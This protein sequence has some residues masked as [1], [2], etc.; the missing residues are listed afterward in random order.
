MSL[1]TV[2]IGLDAF[3]C[4]GR[5]ATFALIGNWGTGKTYF[6][7]EFIHDWAQRSRSSSKLRWFSRLGKRYSARKLQGYAY[8]SLFGVN[9]LADFRRKVALDARLLA[10]V[11]DR[12]TKR[13][14]SIVQRA[15]TP[16]FWKRSLQFVKLWSAPF[17]ERFGNFGPLLDEA[18]QSE[19]EELVVCVDD[20]ERRG[21]ELTVKDVLGYCTYLRDEKRCRVI[22]IL[23]D[24]A[25]ETADKSDFDKLNEKVFDHSIR[26]EPDL[27]E[28]LRLALAAADGRY[29][30][31]K[32]WC[33]KLGEKNIRVLQRLRRLVDAFG[34]YFENAPLALRGEL[35]RSASLL[36][37]A[38]YGSGDRV[39]RLS[40][41]RSY[42]TPTTRA[43]LK[44]E[45]APGEEA[46]DQILSRMSFDGL[47]PL[48]DVIINYLQTGAIDDVELRSVVAES[49]AQSA[50][51]E[52]EINWREAWGALWSSFHWNAETA[53]AAIWKA[54]RANAAF[55]DASFVNALAPL[56]RELDG[57]P[58]ATEFIGEWVRQNSALGHND[59]FDLTKRASQSEIDDKELLAAMEAALQVAVPPPTFQEAA[60]YLVENRFADGPYQ[61]A[62]SA[63]SVD[64]YEQLFRTLTGGQLH[65]ALMALMRLPY[66]KDNAVKALE[67]IGG[68]NILNKWRV[69]ARGVKVP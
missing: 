38:H 54:F 6:W 34:P 69:R 4:S 64:D 60:R 13:G 61:H 9:S 29:D 3:L 23:N 19:V 45:A 5:P 32:Q 28:C 62:L 41:L 24:D 36:T 12:T 49:G 1:D 33:R 67:R 44:R 26:F 63:G 37:F 20:F 39:P 22:V 58:S 21:A 16:P 66:S 10:D 27:E 15:V 14:I 52:D 43:I 40:V 48:D 25:L 30:L 35:A 51:M 59:A 31:I 47:N 50:R 55:V 8:V 46:A 17:Y 18:I 2:K 42:H 7:Q 68:D 56:L 53:I 11:G 57:V 65:E